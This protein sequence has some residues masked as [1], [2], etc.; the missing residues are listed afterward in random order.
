MKAQTLDKYTATDF[1]LLYVF[2]LLLKQNFW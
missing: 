2:Y 1:L